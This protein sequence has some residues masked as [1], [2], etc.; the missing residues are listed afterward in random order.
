MILDEFFSSSI[1][2]AK[3]LHNNSLINSKTYL[4]TFAEVKK[5]QIYLQLLVEHFEYN[6]DGSPFFSHIFHKELELVKQGHSHW[7][8]QGAYAPS[9]PPS[10][11]APEPK[12]VQ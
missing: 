1:S 8:G 4:F 10:T 7:G 2:M 5:S 11:S 12:M 3:R 9:P 6:S